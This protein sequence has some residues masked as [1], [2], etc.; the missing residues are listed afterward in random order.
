VR[1]AIGAALAEPTRFGDDHARTYGPEVL[2]PLKLVWAILNGPWRRPART[3]RIPAILRALP[4]PFGTNERTPKKERESRPSRLATSVMGLR[5][6]NLSTYHRPSCG[7]RTLETI[8]SSRR[9]DSPIRASGA[10]V[11]RRHGMSDES[12][13]GRGQVADD[14]LDTVWLRKANQVL[15][16]LRA[17]RTC[18]SMNV[19]GVGA[20]SEIVGPD[21]LALAKV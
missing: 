1:R 16:S 14:R 11:G 18:D 6:S 2:E 8:L 3:G 7:E 9:Q 10:V 4:V 21:A 20:R 12:A 13:R 15:S 17:R 19:P 5:A